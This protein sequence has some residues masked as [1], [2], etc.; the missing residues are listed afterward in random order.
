VSY[1]RRP[2]YSETPLCEPQFLHE[3]CSVTRQIQRCRDVHHVATVP[4]RAMEQAIRQMYNVKLPTVLLYIEFS[5]TIT[6][7]LLTNYVDLISAGLSHKCGYRTSSGIVNVGV[8]I[9]M[10]RLPYNTHHTQ[11]R[12]TKNHFHQHFC[13]FRFYDKIWCSS[14]TVGV[15]Y[16][17]DRRAPHRSFSL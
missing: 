17:W 15:G 12:Q 9:C 7:V 2:E 1:P 3:V 8:D 5:T 11:Y 4:Q 6:L 14:V 16:S 13:T 10:I